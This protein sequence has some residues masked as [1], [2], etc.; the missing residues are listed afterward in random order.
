MWVIEMLYIDFALLF[1]DLI[2]FINK[3]VQTQK[4]GYKQNLKIENLRTMK[5]KII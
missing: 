4:H 3:L 1:A 5:Q 2:L